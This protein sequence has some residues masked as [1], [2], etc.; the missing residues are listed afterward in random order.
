MLECYHCPTG[1]PNFNAFYNV[2]AENYLIELHGLCSYQRGDLREKDEAQ[3]HKSD[4]GDFELYFIWPNTVIVPGPV[5][6][7]VMP[8]IPVSAGVSIF[9]PMTFFRADVDDAAA[10]PY[11]EYYDE[12]WAE[13]VELV[14]SV[15]RGQESQ[16]LPWGPFFR[17]SEKLLQHAQ[18]LLLEGIERGPLDRSSGDA[19]AVAG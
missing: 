15:Q 1:H 6:C 18:G 5:S 8:L 2:D 19:M 16:Q 14:E 17:D 10:A 12:I 7:M 13:D 9:K 4:W 11:I 3:A